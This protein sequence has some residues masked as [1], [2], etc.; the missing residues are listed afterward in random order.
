MYIIDIYLSP[1]SPSI[2][3]IYIYSQEH[4]LSPETAAPTRLFAN[5]ILP[6]AAAPPQPVPAHLLPNPAHRDGAAPEVSQSL[7]G[8]FHIRTDSGNAVFVSDDSERGEAVV[9]GSRGPSLTED[10]GRQGSLR[11][12]A[13]GPGAGPDRGAFARPQRDRGPPADVSFPFASPS[14]APVT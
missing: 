10:G 1:V 13:A 6:N 7:P 5:Q 12:A 8:I 9:A 14:C 3:T 2:Y 11:P 4:L